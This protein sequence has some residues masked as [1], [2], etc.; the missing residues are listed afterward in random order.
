MKQKRKARFV[1]WDDEQWNLRFGELQEFR[2]KHGHMRVPDRWRGNM[3]LGR[4]VAHQRELYRAGKIE[5]D[6]A[7][8][9]EKLG[10]EWS[11]PEAHVEECDLYLEKMLARLA[12]Y[13]ELYGHDGVTRE[14]DH[15]LARWIIRQRSYRNAGTL[16]NYR[17]ERMDAA[18]FPWEPVDYRWED[19]FAQLRKFRERFGHPQVPVKWKENLKLGRWVGHQRE[20]HR[21]GHLPPEYRRRLEEIGFRWDVPPI[22]VMP[23]RKGDAT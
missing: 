10:M 7:K 8:R 5:P 2:E 11:I 21:E 6:R 19:Q 3:P 15:S 14:R 16:K 4:W 18:G 1:G 12:S 22:P 17:R 9:L 20:L 13:R 23:S